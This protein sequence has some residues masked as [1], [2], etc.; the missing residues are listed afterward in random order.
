MW[1]TPSDLYGR[2]VRGQGDVAR[3][4]WIII[5]LLP[6]WIYNDTSDG[7]RIEVREGHHLRW[8]VL[9]TSVYVVAFIDATDGPLDSLVLRVGFKGRLMRAVARGDFPIG[10]DPG[11]SVAIGSSHVTV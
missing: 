5:F 1:N 10:T 9:V 8:R 2:R 7:P 6:R 11:T 4:R 3:G